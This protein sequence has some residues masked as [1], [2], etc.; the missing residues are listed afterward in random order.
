M[1]MNLQKIIAMTIMAGSILFIIAAFS[2]AS[3]VFGEPSAEKKLKMIMQSLNQ[4]K[5]SQLLFAAGAI[6]TAIGIVLLGYLFRYH[7]IANILY[8]SAT[9]IMLAAIFWSWHVYMRAVDPPAFTEGRIPVW[10]FAVYT[11]LTQ[12]GLI[13]LGVAL[14]RMGLPA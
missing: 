9:M 2:P 3:M 5:I 11:L 7:T 13:V 6:V 14:L 4:W 1:E 12:A 8:L 10:L